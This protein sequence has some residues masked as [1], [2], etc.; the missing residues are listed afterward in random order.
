MQAGAAAAETKVRANGLGTCDS[1]SNRRNLQ[2]I[3]ANTVL[4]PL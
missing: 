2:M 1:G 3:A 4:S